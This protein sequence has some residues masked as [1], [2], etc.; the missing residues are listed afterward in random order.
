MASLAPQLKAYATFQQHS[1]Q[2]QFAEQ[3][4]DQISDFLGSTLRVGRELFQ[5]D[6]A[7]ASAVQQEI[8]MQV[9]S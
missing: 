9:S 6:S 8:G 2:I 1:I 5:F 3:C 7:M 4:P